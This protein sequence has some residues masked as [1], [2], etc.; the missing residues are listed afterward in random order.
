[1]TFHRNT[2]RARLAALL[3]LP[4]LG[5]AIAAC[6]TGNSSGRAV[7]NLPGGSA[8]RAGAPTLTQ[9]QG[10][11]D[12]VN[13]THCMRAHGVAVPDPFH[14]PG[15]AGLSIDLPA[16]TAANRPAFVACNHFIEP[17]IQMKNAHA[18]AEFAPLLPALT[19]YARCMRSHDIAMLDPT[20]EGQ[21][22]LGNVPGIHNDFGRYT[23]QF[24]A[25]DAACRHFLP[26]SV[27]DDGTGP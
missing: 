5:L 26:A 12:F 1:M 18:Q 4:I 9:A 2:A 7:A 6:S 3:A 16:E 19:R 13:F 17:V 14:R 22:N 25:A 21:L 10:D 23:P 11:A 15:H 27:H 20:P 24:H 8:H